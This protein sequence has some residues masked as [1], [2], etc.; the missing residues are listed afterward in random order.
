MELKLPQIVAI[1]IYNSGF[2]V[3]NRTCSRTASQAEDSRF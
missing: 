1:G 2:A 3:R